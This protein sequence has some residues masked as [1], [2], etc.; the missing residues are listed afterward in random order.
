MTRYAPLWQQ[1]GSYPAQLDRSLISTLWPNGGVMA[2]AVTA[3]ANS[4]NVSI[5]PGS[6]VVPLAAGQGNA[7]CRWD[8]AELVALAAAPPAGQS[9]IDVVIAQVRDNQIDGGGN[10]DFIFTSV[11]GVPAVSNPAV[12]ATPAN[13]Y[14]LANVTVPG[15]AANLNGATITPTRGP[16][17]AFSHPYRAQLYRAAAY[18][19][20]HGAN[21][22]IAL[23]SADFDPSGMLQGGRLVI[24]V[25]GI[26]LVSWLSGVANGAANSYQGNLYRNGAAGQGGVGT[27]SPASGGLGGVSGGSRLLNLNPGDALQVN[28]WQN[29]GAQ[30][31]AFVGLAQCYVAA[32]LLSGP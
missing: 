16:L 17:G 26:W 25:P 4:M 2:G 32:H 14:A 6:A 1:A 18:T 3:V 7:L 11:T 9:R 28:A 12:P 29:S 10:N 13:A 21:T 24:P 22:L 27:V 30:L 19:V 23:D 31:A 8:A 5:A 15:A 20:P